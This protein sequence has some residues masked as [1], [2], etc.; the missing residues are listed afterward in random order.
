MSWFNDHQPLR[1]DEY[2]EPDEDED[3][4]DT[5]TCPECGASVFEDAIQCPHCSAYISSSTSPWQGRPI[6]WIALGL[7]GI[8]GTILGLLGLLS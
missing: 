4:Y 5:V 1:D 7:L 8:A 2:P 3:T 6:L